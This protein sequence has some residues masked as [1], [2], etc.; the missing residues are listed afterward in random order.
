MI[1]P[2][3]CT[4]TIDN[5]KQKAATITIIDRNSKSYTTLVVSLGNKNSGCRISMTPTK[6][7]NVKAK[8]ILFRAR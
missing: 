4:Y 7:N 6:L 2:C 8:L 1:L 5:E 3:S